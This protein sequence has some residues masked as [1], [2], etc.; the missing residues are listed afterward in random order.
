MPNLNLDD[1]EIL[2]L[3]EA[4]LSAATIAIVM[5]CCKKT[6]LNH[7]KKIRENQNNIQENNEIKKVDRS[8]KNIPLEKILLL[9]NEGKTDQEIADICGCKRNNITARLNRAG[10]TGRKSRI[11]NIPL[12]NKISESLRGKALGSENYKY[13]GYSDTESMFKYYKNRAR[14]LQKTYIYEKLRNSNHKCEIC[15]KSYR[16]LEVHHLYS[17]KNIINNFLEDTYSGNPD[18]FSEELQKI[19]IFTDLNNLI[20][21][22]PNCH[23]EI[24][25]KDNPELSRYII[26]DPNDIPE[27]P[28]TIDIQVDSSESKNKDTCLSV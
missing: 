2:R 5:K 6:I 25:K 9:H 20:I 11:N 27:S 14:G 19:P 7:L 22:C 13:K 15:G 28:T 4:G 23:A 18:T 8:K 21:V 24:H 3:S 12:R 10:I 1:N 26:D 16:T 17:F